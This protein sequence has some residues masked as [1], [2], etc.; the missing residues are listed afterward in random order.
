MSKTHQTNENYQSNKK[1]HSNET[2][3]PNKTSSQ[4]KL[5]KSAPS[6][7][8]HPTPTSSRKILVAFLLNLGFS[9]FEFIGGFFTNSIAITSDAIHD[10]GDAASIGIAYFLERYSRK[11]PD[12]Q[13]TYGY[14]RYSVIG[15]LITTLILLTGSCIVIVSSVQRIFNPS[16]V[17]Y[18]GMILLAI[19]GVV[20]N[21]IAAWYT[22]EGDSLNQKSVNLHMLE[23]VLGWAVVLVGA[24]VM[25]F[26]DIE[27]LDPLLSIAVAIFILVNALRNFKEILDLFLEKT[28]HNISIDDLRHHILELKD[29]QSVHHIHVWSMDGYQNY[30]T[31]HVVT[32]RPTHALKE[33]IREELHEHNIS[34]VTIEFES[35]SEHCDDTTCH[36]GPTSHVHYHH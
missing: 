30:A 36:I 9:I 5:T 1:L 29:I 4:T 17:N 33:S 28:P 8:A 34:H 18:D 23:D 16:P 6:P 27:I 2:Y 22:H 21:F 24:I 11:A 13:Y 35:P 12:Q 15:G 20:I 32:T 26:T 3:Q 10:L 7:N 25:R 31:M 14:L 19:F